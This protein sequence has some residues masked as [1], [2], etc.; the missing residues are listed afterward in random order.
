MDKRRRS[1]L[2]SSEDSS[3]A[4]IS[5]INY[6]ESGSQEETPSDEEIPKFG[7]TSTLNEKEHK[8]SE[9]ITISMSQAEF[10]LFLA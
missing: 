7:E 8:S 3:T 1:I 2:R 6:M 5:N 9:K 4:I 10:L